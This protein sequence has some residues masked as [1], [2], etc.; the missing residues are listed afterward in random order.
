MINLLYIVSGTLVLVLI[1]LLIIIFGYHLFISFKE[2]KYKKY[3][4]KWEPVIDRYLNKEYSLEET[5]A[6]FNKKYNILYRFFKPYLINLDGKKFYRLKELIKELKLND[7][8]LEKL[9]NGNNNEKIK[10]ATFLGIINEFRSLP[11]LKDLLKSDNDYLVNTSIRA[12]AEIGE[13]DLFLPVIKTIL[14]RTHLT[15]EA[16]TEIIIKFGEDICQYIITLLKKWLEGD[17]NFKEVFEVPEFQIISLFIDVLGY[18][19]YSPGVKIMENILKNSSNSEIL[20]H[21]FKALIKIKYPLDIDLKQYLFHEDW[22]VRSQC[23][24]F[25]GMIQ[26]KKYVS[27]LKQLVNDDKWWVKYYAASSLWRIGEEKVL[28]SIIDDGEKGAN[29]SRYVLNRKS[30]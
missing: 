7:F 10:A 29:I 16:V 14:S 13:K 2:K 12:I 21:I 15:Y 9:K 24:K 22:V 1:I 4:D 11:Y 27:E 19:R 25:V 23:A 8:F 28:K 6:N 18:F 20:I 26:D 17:F 3:H 30:N 5:A